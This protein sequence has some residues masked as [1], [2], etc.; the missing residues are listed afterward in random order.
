MFCNISLGIIGML[1]KHEK[2]EL[3]FEDINCKF[4]IMLIN[5]HSSISSSSVPQSSLWLTFSQFVW[6]LQMSAQS[7]DRIL[8]WQL[9]LHFNLRQS[10]IINSRTD[11]ETGRLSIQTTYNTSSLNDQPF[12]TGEGISGLACSVLFQMN[13]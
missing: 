7:R 6:H 8:H 10:H 5:F 2:Y 9:A 12:P 11:S 13:D 1:V 4:K 3:N